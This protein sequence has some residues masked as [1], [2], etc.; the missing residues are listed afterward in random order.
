MNCDISCI[1]N[2]KSLIGHQ[3]YA[4]KRVIQVCMKL[5]VNENQDKLQQPNYSTKHITQQLEGA[6]SIVD[7]AASITI[8]QSY[9][10]A[11][12]QS[13]LARAL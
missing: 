9:Y 12:R 10:L 6:L 3:S 11:K 7:G 13:Q 1:F 2:P 4:A 5:K 8:G